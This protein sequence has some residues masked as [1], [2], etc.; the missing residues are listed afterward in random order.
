MRSSHRGGR[1]KASSQIAALAFAALVLPAPCP[2]ASAAAEP[3]AS[4]PA[5]AVRDERALEVARRMATAL[6]GARALRVNLDIGYD[7]VQADGQAIEF[8]A[9]RSL[10][11]RRPDRVRV[12]AV[13]RSGTRRV[14]VYDGAQIALADASHAVYATAAYRGDL[15][16][17]LAYLHRELRMPTPL[18]ESL[19]T[20]LY[21]RLAESD[22]IR[23]VDEQ[24]IGGVRCDHLAFRNE[25]NGLQIWVPREGA[26]LPKRVV[27]TYERARGRPQ[28]RADLRDWDLSPSLPDSLFAFRPEPGAERI[29]FRASG[30]A[31]LPGLP[32]EEVSR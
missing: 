30:G 11:L 23:W 21:A 24:S 32:V 9:T 8:G 2:L 4:P 25:E 10:A 27:V 17:V 7:A 6:S 29:Q 26:P 3:T 14:L 18:G 28:F 13:E 22:S 19:S 12:E 1:S 31:M 5:G 20:D 16:G 15:D